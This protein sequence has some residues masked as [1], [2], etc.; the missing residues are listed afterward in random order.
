MHLSLRLKT[1]P[2]VGR[3]SSL[4]VLFFFRLVC[5]RR[6]QIFSHRHKTNARL[7]S[8][9]RKGNSVIHKLRRVPSLPHLPL[10]L[11]N[12]HSLLLTWMS[13]LQNNFKQSAKKRVSSVY[14]TYLYL[15]SACQEVLW[16]CKLSF[17]HIYS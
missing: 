7:S 4:Y 6:N 3:N 12:F 11:I 10:I 1:F 5:V 9:H 2:S 8:I 14:I 15:S 17:S 13:S 16:L